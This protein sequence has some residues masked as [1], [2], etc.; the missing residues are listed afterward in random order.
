[1]QIKSPSRVFRKFGQN[2]DD[3]LILG[4]ED[5]YQ[6]I[7]RAIDKT[8]ERITGI[9][10]SVPTGSAGNE[11]GMDSATNEPLNVVLNL[12]RNA[13]QAFI[14]DISRMQDEEVSL[15]LKYS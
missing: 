11:L 10:L 3:G 2:I 9:N 14:N 13:Y 6:D 1:M 4:L 15:E 12:G 8:A 5:G 7:G